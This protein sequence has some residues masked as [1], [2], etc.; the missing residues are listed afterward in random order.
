[1][2]VLVKLVCVYVK[3]CGWWWLGC[4]CVVYLFGL[5]VGGIRCLLLLMVSVVFVMLGVFVR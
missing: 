2:V 5:V 4:V 3:W 1:M